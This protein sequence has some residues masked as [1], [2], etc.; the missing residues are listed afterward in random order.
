[1]KTA[2]IGWLTI[3]A[4]V[5][6]L[7]CAHAFYDPS[8][9]RWINRDPLVE[10]V[11]EFVAT[12]VE[13]PDLHAVDFADNSPVNFV[14]RDGLSIWHGNWGGPNWTAGHDATWEEVCDQ[15]LDVTGPTHEA[16]DAQDRC[17]EAHDKCYAACRD[18][19]RAAPPEKWR[20][21]KLA[22]GK[23]LRACDRGLANCLGN[24]GEDPSNNCHAKTAKIVFCIRGTIGHTIFLPDPP[25]RSR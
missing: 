10:H 7:P 12:F 15:G 6:W 18:E 23:C 2:R 25:P 9:Q 13:R 11:G 19:F 20:S 21:A 22:L 1:M 17:Y 16:V 24:L 5:L 3:V 8:A 14:D 4:L